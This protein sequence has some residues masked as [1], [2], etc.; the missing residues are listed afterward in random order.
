M[1]ADVERVIALGA[2]NLTRGFH[3]VVST[4]RARWGPDVEVLGALG[5]GRSYGAPSKFLFRGLPGIL[6]SGLW[7][8]LSRRPPA[9]TRALITDIGND[10]LYGFAATQILAWIDEAIDRLH[11]A[12]ADIVITDLPLA[13]I[14]R[15]SVR[16]FLFFRSLF[17][18]RCRLTLAHVVDTAEEV[19]DG[20]AR[21][22]SARNLRF[23]RLNPDW[24]GFDPIHMRMAVW[25]TA[26]QQILDGAVVGSNDN[27]PW[28][29]GLRLYFMFPERQALFGRERVRPQTG[30]R[31][32]RGGRVWLF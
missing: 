5:H 14:R 22:A 20:I 27:G 4:A 3:T 15:L 24:Y 12:T 10:I 6:E 9:P 17:V 1:P 30:A 8:E 32:E 23:V 29:E 13:T 16:K 25:H 7:Q 2:S 18:P 28:L 26:W 31:L 11:R 19:S 21:L